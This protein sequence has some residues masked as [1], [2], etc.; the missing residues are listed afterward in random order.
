MIKIASYVFDKNN[1]YR[2]TKFYLFGNHVNIAR[3]QVM[4]M[5]KQIVVSLTFK[6]RY[7]NGV[8]LDYY[9]YICTNQPF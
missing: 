8:V 7:K 2:I 4:L 9:I 1:K 3:T 5:V 6:I